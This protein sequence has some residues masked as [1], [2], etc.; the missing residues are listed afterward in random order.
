MKKSAFI[1]IALLCTLIT[2]CGNQNI[3][4]P[5]LLTAEE[6][7]SECE[8]DREAIKSISD[9]LDVIIVNQTNLAE[10]IKEQESAD[11]NS[12][13]EIPNDVNSEQEIPIPT[14]SPVNSTDTIAV[15]ILYNKELLPIPLSPSSTPSPFKLTYPGHMDRDLSIIVSG[16]ISHINLVDE[17]GAYLA[18]LSVLSDNINKLHYLYFYMDNDGT[19][20]KF[21]FEIVTSDKHSYYFGVDYSA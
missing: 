15:S 8:I 5:P 2:G 7:Y 13:Q 19:G 16:T 10:I 9:K 17:K 11:T 20:A 1:T 12:T 18:T 14:G 4:Q 3:N 21:Y 6:F